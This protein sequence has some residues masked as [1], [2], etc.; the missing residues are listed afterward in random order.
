[1]AVMVPSLNPQDD[2]DEVAINAG[3]GKF[4]TV[5]GNVFIHPFISFT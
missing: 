1:M 5:T 4:K 3:A 2:G